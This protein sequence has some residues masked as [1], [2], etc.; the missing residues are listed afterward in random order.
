MQGGHQLPPHLEACELVAC[1]TQ[2]CDANVLGG[3][4]IKAYRPDEAEAINEQFPMACPPGVQGNSND[5]QDQ[6]SPFCAGPCDAGF[7]CPLGTWQPV[8]CAVGRYSRGGA[9]TAKECPSCPAGSVA[10]A[11]GMGECTQCAAGTFQE[12]EGDAGVRSPAS[13][14][15]SA[16]RAPARRYRA[17]RARTPTPPT[18]L[19]PKTAPRPTP[20]HFA[21]TGST[22][23]MPCSAGTVQP[24]SKHPKCDN[25]AA[26][27]FMNASGGTECHACTPASYCPEGASVP[28]PC[29]EGTYSNRTHLGAAA[30]CTGA[31]RLMWGRP[32]YIVV[33]LPWCGWL[34]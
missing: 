21:P 6:S 16:Q 4:Y 14:A 34:D 7:Y 13:P 24:Q 19:A 17:R 11:T 28:L 30:D 2:F 29:S 5:I 23:Q 1:P 9:K 25:C 15:R 12:K 22:E 10:N 32:T 20:G 27:K 26:G 33:S 3:K 8:P 31:G 18:S